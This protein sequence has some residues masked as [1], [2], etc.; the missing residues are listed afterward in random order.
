[1]PFFFCISYRIYSQSQSPFYIAKKLPHCLAHIILSE[2]LLHIE[3]IYMLAH[4]E[5]E[6][7]GPEMIICT[8]KHPVNVQ[9]ED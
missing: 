5:N 8:Y 2:Q 9:V 3:H 4:I 7:T 6:V 1:M